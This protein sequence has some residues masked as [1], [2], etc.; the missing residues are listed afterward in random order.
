MLLGWSFRF[1][2]DVKRSA[3]DPITLICS[4]PAFGYS[5]SGHGIARQRK[6]STPTHAELKLGATQYGLPWSDA[7]VTGHDP[8][9]QRLFL[10]FTED[11]LRENAL[12]R[13]AIPLRVKAVA[14][15]QQLLECEHEA[16]YV[17]KA[18][19]AKLRDPRVGQG[20]EAI[21]GLPDFE[22]QL[23]NRTVFDSLAEE[24][25][26]ISQRGGA[27]VL[28][29]FLARLLS[30]LSSV[31][32]RSDAW[33]DEDRKTLEMTVREA[34]LGRPKGIATLLEKRLADLF[35]FP[36]VLPDIK[37]LEVAGTFEII[38][39]SGKLGA[40]ELGL[41]ELGL[42]YSVRTAEGAMRSVSETYDWRAA[43]AKLVDN[44]TDFAFKGQEKTSLA[45]IGSDVTVSVRTFDGSLPWNKSFAA[46]DPELAALSIQVPLIERITL[47]RFKAD[48]PH[49][50][51]KKIRGQVLEF[52]RKCPLKDQTVLIQAKTSGSEV[53][54]VVAAGVT[55]ASGNFSL[56]YPY[57]RYVAAQALVSL[58]PNS[59][60]TVAIEGDGL[61]DESISDSYL[62]LLIADPDC[63]ET[64]QLADDCDCHSP[65]KAPRLPDHEDLIGSNDYT[66]DIGGACINLSTPNRTISEFAYH[67][68]V[69]T[70]DPD[71]ANYTLAK[72]KVSLTD[73]N[74]R[75]FE[76]SKFDLHGGKQTIKRKPVDLKNPIRW[77]DAP[78]ARNNLNFYQAVT[79][80]TGHVLHY[81][82]VFKADGYSLGNL[83]YSLPLAP[84][85]KKQIV[86]LDSQHSLRGSESQL[87]SQRES[88][89]SS[90]VNERDIVSQLGGNINEALSGRSSA[91]T[92]GVSAGFGAGFSYGPIGV[93][94]G[95]AGGSSSS[96]ASASQ[97]G[98]R[99]TSMFFA[100]KLR[101][102][103]MQNA[104]S[105]RQLN[106]SVVTSVQQGQ[107]YSATT[108]VVANHNH[109]HSLTMM[110]FEVLRHYAI[111]QELQNVEECI[112]VPLLMTNF[113]TENIF[114]WSDVLARNLLP[115]SSN[116][117]LRP[118]AWMR[119][120]PLAHAF[121]ANERI[122]T[123]YANVDFP[124]DRFCDDT[125]DA[126]SGSL[127]LRVRLPRPKT[128]F[129]RILSLPI[130]RKTVTTQGGV[131]V[132]A[133][134]RDAV[135]STAV[136]VL[137]GGLSLLFGGGPEIK[138]HTESR[139]VLT[140]EKIFD[141][142]M[143]LDE[144][145]E[146]VPPAHCIRVFNFAKTPFFDGIS[147]R[148]F[149]FFGDM[150]D[151]AKLWECYASIL[152][153]SVTEL[154]GKFSGN[155]IADWDRLFNDE[156]AP[157]ILARLFD[158]PTFKI[159][160][161]AALDLTRQN[162][163]SGGE[164]FIRYSFRASTTS[165]RSAIGALDLSYTPP[166]GIKNFARLQ[167]EATLDIDSLTVNYETAHYQGRIFSGHVGSDLLD[168]PA[169]TNNKINTPLNTDEKRNPR[170]EDAFIV[171]KLIEHLNSNLEH[172]N[173]ML[174]LNLDPD[175]R[176]MLLDGFNIPVYNEFGLQS[177]IRSLASVVK[178]ELLT[179]AGNS[180][181]FPV[182][183][184]YRVSQSYVVA[185]DEHGDAEVISLLDH[186]KP[187]TPV[188]PYRLSVPS[189]GVFMEA[190]QGACDACEKVKENSSQDWNR[191][192]TDEPTPISAVT[193]P[194]P[195]IVDW[196]AAFK[197]LAAPLVSIQNAP[198][199]PAPGAGLGGLA[200]LL[201]KAGLFKDVAGLDA[202]QQNVIRTYLSNQEN[203]KAFA[204]MAKAMAMQEHNTRYSGN[205]METL[206][207]AKDSGAM[208]AEDYGKA[209]KQH[210]G[211][212]IDGGE[213]ARRA[214]D[215][216]QSAKPSIM[217]KGL[218][219]A[220]DQN[221]AFEGERIDPATGKSEKVKLES[222][223][224]DLKYDFTVPGSITPIKQESANGCWAAVT[225][226]MSNWRTGKTQTVLE[227]VNGVGPEFAPFIQ[228]GISLEK[229]SAFCAKA[230]L[231]M[232]DT[233]AEFPVSVYYDILK[234]HGPI[235]VVD[236]ETA[237]PK[238]LHGRLLVGLKGDD[239]SP[240]TLFDIIDP[241]SGRRYLETL[242]VF[243]QKTEAV[244][245][246]LEA[247]KD[248]EIPLLIYFKDAIANP[249]AATGGGAS[250]G[251]A[252][253]AP[254]LTKPP[255]NG[256][257]NLAGYFV[258]D[259]QISDAEEIA[260][261]QKNNGSW[262]PAT[263]D[264]LAVMGADTNTGMGDMA[265]ILWEIARCP[266][267]SVK[268]VNFTTHA[269]A[270]AIGIKGRNKIM[271]VFFDVAVRESDL[272]D[273]AA[274]GIG[275]VGPDGDKFKIDDVRASFAKDAIFVV[276]GCKAAL[277][278]AVLT[279]LHNLLGIKIIGFKS[280]IIYCP[281]VQAGTKFVRKG[282]KIG[283][284]KPGFSCAT[285]T[286]TDWRGLITHPDAVSVP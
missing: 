47:S 192:K 30:V 134:Q 26:R 109:C 101:Q 171:N 232:A 135:K 250:I 43:K 161:L 148:H 113:T 106:A 118:F 169:Q 143:T 96:S 266:K 204:E 95:V 119:R 239:A 29:R 114:K 257:V 107:Q 27:T 73:E 93:S 57:G 185:R 99:G 195:T 283:L 41:Y 175:R 201:G 226:M 253:V 9:Q 136:A 207:S 178:N 141:L 88:L 177:G 3:F 68:I 242:D 284:S 33:S 13:L 279:A 129:D 42:E 167:A 122:K 8:L 269:N 102:A 74:G 63:E 275:F 183:A 268:R 220:V 262:Y 133:T 17:M 230:N 40:A 190:I 157:L 181:V 235:W 236:L 186:Y 197:E 286:V 111:S 89:A 14:E 151:D 44:R 184:G 180:L 196:K 98:S 72:N 276:Y 51:G 229:L 20:V 194:T 67:A 146:S 132:N 87:I 206:K 38:A 83:L 234:T 237:D 19:P 170:K 23:I 187:L 159:K 231:K 28:Y 105:Y 164:Q 158:T 121:D 145:Y 182:A 265:A 80:A 223:A 37:T 79:V 4:F 205:I 227:F 65:K 240:S 78:D 243:M 144:N 245:R 39:S 137:T 140:T 100:E 199:A 77:Q 179:I 104:E 108:D 94:L 251:A 249:G 126:V 211:M 59:P 255:K 202:T 49:A 50:L 149:D 261:L 52:S 273:L 64:K 259:P 131:D 224:K 6:A 117:Y 97:Q 32:R 155:I 16:L 162:R 81:R 252:P 163:Y 15:G 71:V 222:G 10:N 241:A 210:A 213:S 254:K 24:F 150:Q 110:Y 263:V 233:N 22:L 214:D 35:D 90:L 62:Y 92:S 5:S 166:P 264:F 54:T 147:V 272:N 200:E 86:V 280:T 176:F 277:D 152:G 116:T 58:A 153:I 138:Y 91:E 142:F 248:A 274:P 172:Y 53:W 258:W 75:S 209:V 193:P 208:S 247:V 216:A 11:A 281:P 60:V 139:E 48:D 56:P 154:L 45:S 285:D 76:L 69:R 203:A 66:Q 18:T 219:A 61:S 174:W 238:T 120:H 156:I 85:Q 173:K 212:T 127:T 128:R 12:E 198:P 36:I 217:D 123:K 115:L 25:E 221:R 191:F 2:G 70:S 160:P 31:P 271:D 218:E 256:E 82:A 270:N 1:Q 125:I 34:E 215:L 189:R 246:T 225:T 7:D 55:D 278:K 168:P 244:I 228:A 267:G 112:F 130:G 103:L 124:K 84:G 46:D 165:T 282:T 260:A 21:D 188:P